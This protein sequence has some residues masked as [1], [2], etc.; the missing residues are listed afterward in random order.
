MRLRWARSRETTMTRVGRQAREWFGCD[1]A[2]NAVARVIHLEG[3]I[4]TGHGLVRAIPL[5]REQKL[6][7]LLPR[8]QAGGDWLAVIGGRVVGRAGVPLEAVRWAEAALAG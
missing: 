2:G 8:P 4:I 6:I 1:D 3:P 7:R 5:D